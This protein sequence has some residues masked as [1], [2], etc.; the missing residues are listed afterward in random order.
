MGSVCFQP[1]QA[2]T[3]VI[4]T[5]YYKLQSAVVSTSELVALCCELSIMGL[6]NVDCAVVTELPRAAG[7]NE[8]R[9]I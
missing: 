6:L 7:R 2:A 5:C 4:T 9:Q 1:W 3:Y 8:I